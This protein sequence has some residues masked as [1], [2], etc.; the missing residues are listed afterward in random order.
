MTAIRTVEARVQ[1]VEALLYERAGVELAS[2]AFDLRRFF[3]RIHNISCVLFRRLRI[4][5]PLKTLQVHF[6]AKT[7]K[8]LAHLLAFSETI[9]STLPKPD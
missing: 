6:R 7:Y 5:F 9:L 3:E 8:L 4:L 1:I 2:I